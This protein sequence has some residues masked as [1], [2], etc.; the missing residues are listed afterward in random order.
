MRN[1]T[2]NNRSDAVDEAPALMETLEAA[3]C[4]DV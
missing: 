3:I 2:Y 4:A 1:I